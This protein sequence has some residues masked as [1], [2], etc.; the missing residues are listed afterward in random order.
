LGSFVFFVG[1]VSWIEQPI[2]FVDFEG[3]RV[4]GVLEYGVVAV[5]RGGIVQANTRLCRPTGPV[6]PED[7]AVHGLGAEQLAS[8]RPFADEWEYFA[9]LRE[10]G[11]LAAHYAGVEN[12]LLKAVWPYPRN[13]PD[14]ACPGKRVIDWGPWID[15]ARIYAQLYPDL[16]GGGLESMVQ[17]CGLQSELDLAAN[18]YCPADRC[19]YHRAL[20]D[21]LAGSVL[22]ARLARDT[23]VARLSIMQLL[24]LSTLDPVKRDAL[25]QTELF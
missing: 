19:R 12:G 9:D 13:S 3:S 4:S 17:A 10:Q 25:R 14:F 16:E 22:L 6:R 8:H 24:A 1:Q 5:L 21:A 2:F 23:E 7:T 11:P 15:T 20:Y 18:R